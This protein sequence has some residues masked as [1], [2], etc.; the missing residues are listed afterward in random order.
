MFYARLTV[1]DM[2]SRSGSLLSVG[3]GYAMLLPET[4]GNT[5]DH[6]KC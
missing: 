3:D 5:C 2:R 1:K 6:G 4:K